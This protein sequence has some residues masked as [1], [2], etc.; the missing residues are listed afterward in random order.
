MLIDDLAHTRRGW[1]VRH[2]F[3]HQS[4]GAA[5]QRAVQQI[6]V[7]GD[8]AD[9]GGA[10]VNIARVVIENVFKGGGRVDQI[11][12]GGVQHPFRFTGGARGIEDE[13][14]I[15]GV[16]LDGAVF[17]A[18]VRHQ[19]A[20]PQIA[21]F[22]PVDFTA[23]TF[24]D[25]D[26]FNAVYVRV[27]QR[28]IDV[29]LQRDGATGAQP[30]IR[31]DHQARAGVDN[32]SG[33]CLRR[34]AAK[35]HRVDGA[36]AGAGQHRHRGFRHHRHIDGDHVAFFNPEAEQH[37]GEAAHVRMQF[38]VGDVL[39]LAG[40]VA[41]PDDGGLIAAL[42]EVAVEAVGGEVQGAV[43]IPFDG[44][45]TWREG[46]ILH[47]GVGA[48]PVK[49]F[50]LLAPECIRVCYGLLILRLVLIRVNQATFRNVSGNRVFVYLAHGFFSPLNLL[51]ICQTNVKSRGFDSFVC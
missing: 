33:H 9:I 34:E 19:I 43:F 3:E 17:G 25:H 6:A 35:N 47:A 49:D 22:L 45:V 27:F 18:G 16:H 31:G 46:G 20:P 1:P 39:A 48:H 12:A 32:A 42:G 50:P 37:I 36:D 51:N 4:G 40:V 2:P 10:P 23:G 24:Q 44:N 7:A 15:F 11:A 21:A 30:F 5:G 38:T 26:V 41:F 13:Q 29:F 8:P 28:V 14:R